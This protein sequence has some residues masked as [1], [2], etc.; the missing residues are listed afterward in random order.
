[1]TLALEIGEPSWRHLASKLTSAEV[2]EWMAFF[3]LRHKRQ[4]EA[5]NKARKG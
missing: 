4:E 1:M 2:S 5:M 3:S